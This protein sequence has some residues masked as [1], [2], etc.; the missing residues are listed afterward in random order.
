MPE[1]STA[2]L[3]PSSTALPPRYLQSSGNAYITGRTVSDD[4]PTAKA[5]QAHCSG[6]SCG[7]NIPHWD[8][9]VTKVNPSGSALVYSTFLG[10]E[11]NE[12]GNGI[13]VD[14]TGNAYVTGFTTSVNFPTT[15]NVLQPEYSDK[16]TNS[17][18]HDA[19]VT[20]LSP[21]GSFVYSTYLGGTRGSDDGEGIAVDSAG[22]AYVAGGTNS[23]E[24]PTVNAIQPT[25]G[26][27][28]NGSGAQLSDAFVSKVNSAG[29]AL[30]YSTYIGGFSS[31][32]AKAIALDSARN[33]YVTGY[34][35][36]KFPIVNPFQPHPIISGHDIT[37]F[38]TKLN[39][40]GSAFTYSAYLGGSAGALQ[41]SN[42][43]RCC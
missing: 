5:A 42:L 22:D 41:I 34:A 3:S 18:E 11:R 9:F 25:I 4:F 17:E 38:V 27:G 21:A 28:T 12:F 1:A 24:F 13:A 40:T 26:P 8:A 30:V 43:V 6:N 10:G 14:S 36:S 7:G 29:S 2:M 16:G 32:S 19:F 31:D 35:G 37:A 23:A 39:P 33:A 20:K 15:P